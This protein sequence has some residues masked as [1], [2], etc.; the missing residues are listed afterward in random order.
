MQVYCSKCNTG[1]EIAEDL[2]IEDGQKLRCS[3]CGNIFA[4]NHA[5][6]RA[7]PLAESEKVLLVAEEIVAGAVVE[8]AVVEVKEE[9]PV[10]ADDMKA[11]FERLSAKTENLFQEENELPAY[12]RNLIKFKS[13]MGFN[14]KANRRYFALS[15]LILLLLAMY[16]Y[17][18]E[19]V[20]TAPFMEK[21]YQFLN[22][23]ATIA[24]EGLE[25][26]NI[27]WRDF[28]DDF[29][30]KLEIKGFVVNPTKKEVD[31]PI[32]HIEML[33]KDAKLLQMLDE[34]SDVQRLKAGGRVAISIIVTKPSPLTKYVYL[35]FID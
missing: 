26:Q 21:A 25:F 10:V 34:R 1:Y 17:R 15:V 35:T 7:T 14:N 18:Y 28:D 3:Y 4:F 27:V 30:R 31:L 8:E 23:D 33:D 20:R 19:I 32:I 13:I 9:T 11:I 16:S 12:K 6:L 22:I 2:A 5:N 29:V 24:G